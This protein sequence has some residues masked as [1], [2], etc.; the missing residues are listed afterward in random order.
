M[1]KIA[2]D[3]T[4]KNKFLSTRPEILFFITIKHTPNDLLK[5]FSRREVFT[6]KENLFNLIHENSNNYEKNP[7]L[8]LFNATTNSKLN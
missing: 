1:I 3:G 6:I 5:F 8:E 2:I 7:A 4:F